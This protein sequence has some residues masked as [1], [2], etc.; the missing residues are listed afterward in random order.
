MKE[1][2]ENEEQEKL[3]S[4]VSTLKEELSQATLS[5]QELEKKLAE[6]A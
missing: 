2:D 1:D 5:K 4:C 3:K 6:M